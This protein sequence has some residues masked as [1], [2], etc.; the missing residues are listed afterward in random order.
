MFGLGEYVPDPTE[1][2]VDVKDLPAPQLGFYR[3]NHKPTVSPLLT[4]IA[5][6]N[7]LLY[8]SLP[9][10]IRYRQANWRRRKDD[11]GVG[12]AERSIVE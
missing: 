12:T 8:Q 3:R 9:T 10:C 11:T 1:G 4:P 2:L 6:R 5:S 7:I